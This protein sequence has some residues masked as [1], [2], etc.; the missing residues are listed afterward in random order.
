MLRNIINNNFLITI[1]DTVSQLGSNDSSRGDVDA[2]D[3]L[4]AG[5]EYDKISDDDAVCV[6][7]VCAGQWVG[8]ISKITSLISNAMLKAS[9]PALQ[10]YN[11]TTN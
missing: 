1:L 2:H 11:N 6:W 7:V 9:H 8:V 4:N 10:H 5:G 3:N